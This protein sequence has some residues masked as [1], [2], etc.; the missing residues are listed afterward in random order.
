[1]KRA[2]ELY[3]YSYSVKETYVLCINKYVKAMRSWR[4]EIILFFRQL[5]KQ[6]RVFILTPTVSC[7]LS[8][9]DMKKKLLITDNKSTK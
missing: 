5:F 4:T 7:K 9:Y 6:Y 8:H 3:F 1:M 2:V